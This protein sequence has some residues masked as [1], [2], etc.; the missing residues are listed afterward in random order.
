[1]ALM[2]LLG[3]ALT[4]GALGLVALAGYLLALRLVAGAERD[5][6]AFAVAWLLSM[7][8]VAV[9][10]A[11]A[12][13]VFGVLRLGWALTLLTAGVLVL[14]RATSWPDARGP[15]APAREVFAGTWRRLRQHPIVALL[16]V[17]AAGSELLRGL[18]RPP[19]SWDSL[20]YHLWL[21]AEWL[22]TGQI[23]PGLGPRVLNFHGFQPANGSLYLW[24]W[25][26]PSH[27]ELYVNLASALPWLLLAAATGAVAREL[28]ARQSWPLAAGVVAV[29]PMVVRFVGAQYA[30][31]LVA[32][33]LVAAVF[34]SLRWLVAPTTGGAILVGLG[35]G[36]A[37]GAKVVATVY[38]AAWMAAVAAGALHRRDALRV[39][40]AGGVLVL[41]LVGSL[42]GYWLV[43]NWVLGAGVFG[44][45]CEP[46]LI[47]DGE[48]VGAGVGVRFP[49]PDSIVGRLDEVLAEGELAD[50]LLGVPWAVA[51]ELG[52]GPQVV[53]LLPLFLLPWLLSAERRGAGWLVWSQLLVQGAFWLT[54]PVSSYGWI[55]ASPRFLGGA[56]ALAIA[57]G[58]AVLETR[59]ARPRATELLAV[60]LMIQ[61]LLQLRA[62]MPRGVRLVLAAIDLAALLAIIGPPAWGGWCRRHSGRL[63]A[64]TAL[65]VWSL[66]P[67]W[68]T[69]RIAD[70]GRAM[71]KEST[72][73]EAPLERFAAAWNW[74][75][76]FAGRSTV[77]VVGW[78][79]TQW[80]YPAMGPR[81]ERRAIYV[82]VNAR[83]GEH[84]ALYPQCDPRGEVAADAWLANLLRRDVRFL[85]V[86]RSSDDGWP[87]EAG[88]AAAL[89]GLFTPRF[90]DDAT[91]IY[92]FS[93]EAARGVLLAMPPPASSP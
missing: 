59:V 21:A 81:L 31:L 39:R 52:I 38:V 36:L 83:D 66:V 42:G 72:V 11:L 10:L 78:P 93:L 61:S 62:E 19:L 7:L 75:D 41:A 90:A 26:A 17:H 65:L 27:S 49:V 14:W 44:E 67:L 9:G 56:L 84:A 37:A 5:P 70:R 63:A 55:F 80:L 47:S 28:G 34:F 92:E 8:A 50:A 77:A 53:L 2:D 35:L 20:V 23:A 74:L 71:A 33:A 60:A 89:P 91:Q 58:T 51:S 13:G 40:L 87:V 30:E 22:Q 79:R 46:L 69:F 12:L 85:L 29:T 24:W 32:G 1:M 54:V 68:S 18:L 76:R 57:G 15:W 64:A 86:M 43:R 25:L 6:L 4:V 88:W 73:H 45:R 16:V 48:A 3:A 82:N